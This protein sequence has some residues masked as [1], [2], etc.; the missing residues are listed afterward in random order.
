[1]STASTS[2]EAYQDRVYAFEHAAS[3]SFDVVFIGDSLTEGGLWSEYFEHS[4]VANRGIYG[5]TTSGVLKRMDSILSTQAK[6]A[7]ILIGVNDIFKGAEVD[8]IETRYRTIIDR[9]L[10]EGLEVYIQST[11]SV[12]QRDATS[13]MINKLNER[14]AALATSHEHVYYIDVISSLTEDDYK[15]DGIHLGGSGYVKWKQAVKE[16]VE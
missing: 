10:S 4:R 12:F 13:R 16:Y 1:M 5:D 11:L 15:Q 7:F 9:L 8:E 6:K 14:L 2:T 3:G